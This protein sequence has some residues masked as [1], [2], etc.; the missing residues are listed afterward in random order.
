MRS[1]VGATGSREYFFFLRNEKEMRVRGFRQGE[2]I[3]ADMILKTTVF[4][5]ENI[6]VTFENSWFCDKLAGS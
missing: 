5:D 2:K 1:K 4:K 3:Q 6:E